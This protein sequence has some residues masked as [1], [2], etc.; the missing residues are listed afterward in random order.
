MNVWD[1]KSGRQ[2]RQIVW[3]TTYSGRGF[4]NRFYAGAAENRDAAI[5][6]LCPKANRGLVLLA[7]MTRRAG[8]EC[9]AHIGSPCDDAVCGEGRTLD[10]A[11]I[12][13]VLAVEKEIQHAE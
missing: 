10:H 5:R 7:P 4:L 13:L 9:Y 12:R 6:W 1:G 2:V 3:G 11:L 8:W